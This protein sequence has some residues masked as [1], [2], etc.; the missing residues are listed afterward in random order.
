MNMDKNYL[1][2]KILNRKEKEWD[3]AILLSRK[4]S[5]SIKDKKVLNTF[6][7]TY[8]NRIFLYYYFNKALR[9]N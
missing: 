7:T 6:K 2:I 3:M 4:I 5:E 8:L 1:I 9:V